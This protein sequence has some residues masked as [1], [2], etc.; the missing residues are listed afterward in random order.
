LA[1]F[2][3]AATVAA[4][5]VAEATATEGLYAVFE[6]SVGTF[7]CRLE[8]DKAPVTVGNFV[9]LAEGTQEFTD[10]RT[11]EPI[12]RRFFDGLKFH[13]VL[14][15]FVVQGGDP[16]GDGTGGPG[17]EF[18]DEFD[19][20]E[21][22]DAPGVLAMANAGS[23]KNGSQFFVTLAP[24]PHLDGHHTIFGHVVAGLDVV[25]G[26]AKLPR[27]GI[28]KSTPVTDIVMRRVRI[29][30]T[31]AAATAFDAGAAFASQSTMRARRAA[32][33]QAQ[34]E[35]FH[36][37]VAQDRA[38]AVRTP[39]GLLYVVLAA[40]NGDPP[41][42]GDTI[43]T[44]CTGYLEKDGT[45][46]WSTHDSGEPFRTVI[47]VG[48]VIKAWEEAYLD[49]RPGERRRLIV[50]PEL[51]YGAAGKPKAGIPANATLIFDI[52]LLAVERH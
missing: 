13:R 45:R 44:H 43:S 38:R 11:G 36:A 19:P 23:D 27:T 50:P 6:T 22:F 8:P 31:G 18:M 25:L 41:L 33:Q 49:M 47:G 2:A 10:P 21:H 37:Q 40:G 34:A 52:E 39:S 48:K 3:V 1:L 12:R 9:G 42:A 35:A 24:A 7:V 28:E 4:D 32:M 14:P 29:V 20:S 30:R 51:A 17:Y 15:G 5:P 16:K 46:F 26:M